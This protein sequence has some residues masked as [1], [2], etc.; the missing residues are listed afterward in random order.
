[1][2][3]L[4]LCHTFFLDKLREVYDIYNIGFYDYNQ[5]KIDIKIYDINE[6][7]NLAPW[8]PDLIFIGD[9]SFPILFTGLESIDI[10]TLWYSVDT[11]LH[12]WH[13]FYSGI[14]D[15]VLFAQKFPLEDTINYNFNNIRLWFPLYCNPDIHK[16]LNLTK[17]YDLCFIG[18]LNKNLNNDRVTFISRLKNKI[19]NFYV[20]EGEFVD[21]FN[22]SIL[23]L[24]QAANNDINFRTFEAM[25]CGSL[26]LNERI[27]ANGFDEIFKEN[28]D[29]ICY[30]R[31]NIDE[32]IY[33]V[34]YFT[35][36]IDE[37]N[38]IAANG[39]N[40]VKEQHT[41]YNRRDQFIKLINSLN[42]NELKIKRLSNVN[43]I[44]FYL[45][46]A[47]IAASESYSPHPISDLYIE[48]TQKLK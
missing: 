9:N 10:P 1:M 27:V 39:Y 30:N 25:S 46:M 48:M 8:K 33:K 34:E 44:K 24:N 6:I 45:K 41:I 5:R 40:L 43:D 28:R 29:M 3:I 21:K 16:K 38:E 11:H 42:L 17:K 20:G 4:S 13:I 37:T 35:K 14:F 31:D 2:K 47:Y 22:E 12:Q 36:N 7:I 15:I 32:I 23:V 18:S 19:D 26:L